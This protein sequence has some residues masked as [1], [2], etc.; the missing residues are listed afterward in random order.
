MPVCRPAIT[1][2][3]EYMHLQDILVNFW[4]Q[5]IVA[6]IKGFDMPWDLFDILL[7]T[8]LFYWAYSFI[9]VRRA[10]KLAIGIVL[11]LVAYVISDILSLRAVHQIIAGVASFGILILVII[12]QPELRDV[13]EKIGSTPFGFKN[14]GSREQAEL[15]NTIN[16]VVDAAIQIAMEN[17]DGALIVIEGTT[18]LGDYIDK[19]QKLDA[20]VSTALLRNIFVNRSALHD[21]AVVISGNR[22]AAAGCKL[23]LTSNEDGVK[24]LGTRHRAAVGI[25]EYCNDCVVV[26][27]SEERHIISVANAG[28]LKRDYN[29]GVADLRD[30]ERGKEIQNALRKDL[31]RIIANIDMAEAEK[32]A[33]RE[34]KRKAKRGLPQTLRGR[35][36]KTT[37][38]PPV[39]DSQQAGDNQDAE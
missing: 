29:R 19:G 32:R 26:V 27:V 18:K 34:K 4:E 22:I 3:G 21:G 12:F 17:E 33:E 37:Q 15:T 16:A 25:T 31:F 13:L 36:T 10:G 8:A 11:V 6:P 24:G 38:N 30:E 23:P 39:T 2:D 9:R 35:R 20:A 7:L 1:K 14:M 28:V 5:Y